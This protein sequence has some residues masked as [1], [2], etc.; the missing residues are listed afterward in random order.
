YFPETPWWMRLVAICTLALSDV[1]PF[2]IRRTEVYEVAIASGYF[3]LSG[4][5]Y[6]LISRALTDQIRVRRLAV[7][8]LC[9]WFAVGSRVTHVLARI[10]LVVG[11]VKVVRSRYHGRFRDARSELFALVVPCLVC[12]VLL[13]W[14]NYARFDSW[15]EFGVRYQLTVTNLQTYPLLDA[16]R[17]LPGLY[18]YLLQPANMTAQ[19]PFFH[20][21]KDRSE[22][23]AGIL[24]SIPF[25]SILWFAPLMLSNRKTAESPVRLIVGLLVL[26][27]IGHLVFLSAHGRATMRY[28]VDF[29]WL[30]LL[31]ALLVWFAVDRR[32]S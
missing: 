32:L 27:S 2:L 17:I 30:L 9:P 7:C 8:S 3:F 18:R 22:G 25:L 19:F 16:T 13:G 28:D 21:S 26:L 20:L 4:A 24:T 10:L 5:M 23:I 1:A 29:V 14:Y 12:A 11:W 6:W 31:A 15:T